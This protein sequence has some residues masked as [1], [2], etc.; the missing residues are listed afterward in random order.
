L[1]D[2]YWEVTAYGTTAFGP[3]QVS[4]GAEHVVYEKEIN[5]ETDSTTGKLGVGYAASASLDLSASV[6]YGQTPEY[7]REVKGFLAMTWRYDAPV[8][9]GGTK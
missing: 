5:G 6:E 8:K 4:A 1:E 3:L 2:R 7:D 9:K